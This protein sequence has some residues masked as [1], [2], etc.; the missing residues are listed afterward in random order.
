MKKRYII[1][2]ASSMCDLETVVS[3]LLNS[4]W[5]LAGGTFIDIRNDGKHYC[6]ALYHE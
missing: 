4:G 3:D 1:S 2:S 6:Q 5:K